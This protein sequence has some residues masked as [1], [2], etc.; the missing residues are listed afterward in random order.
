MRNI[1]VCCVFVVV[2]FLLV[3]LCSIVVADYYSGVLQNTWLWTPSYG[4]PDHY[5][6]EKTADGGENW[7]VLD[8]NV[9]NTTVDRNGEQVVMFVYLSLREEDYQLRVKSVDAAGNQSPYSDISD[10][11]HIR[12]RP[13]QPQ[14]VTPR[15]P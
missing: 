11:L 13:G 9:P 6:V 3:S 15:S 10:V 8:G 4:A 7:E 12:I 2:V 5:I 1:K 14:F